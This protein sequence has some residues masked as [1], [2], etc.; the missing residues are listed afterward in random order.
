MYAWLCAIIYRGVVNR[1]LRNELGVWSKMGV[2]VGGGGGELDLDFF[3][4]I[5]IF[6]LPLIN[7]GKVTRTSEWVVQNLRKECRQSLCIKIESF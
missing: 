2:V 6:C 1:R 7:N 4:R 3:F 5:T